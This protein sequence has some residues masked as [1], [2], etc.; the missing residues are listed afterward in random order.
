MTSKFR[1]S[2]EEADGPNTKI[3]IFFLLSH[4][5]TGTYARFLLKMQKNQI[6]SA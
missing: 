3:K 5:K 2:A 1:T 4:E 6:D